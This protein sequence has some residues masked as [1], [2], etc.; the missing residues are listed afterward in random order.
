MNI[1]DI[2]IVLLLILGLIVGFKKGVIKSGVTL[3]GTIL[4][5][6]IS[7]YLKNPISAFMYT[8]FPFFNFGGAFAGITIINVLFYEGIAFLLVFLVLSIVLKLLIK[9]SGFTESIL[10]AT[11]ILSIPSKIL[12]AILGVI[13]SYVLIFIAL[14]TLNHFAFNVDVIKESNLTPKILHNTPILS[15]VMADKFKAIEEIA[16]LKTKYDNTKDKT[17]YNKEALEILLKYDIITAKNAEKINEKGK[18]KIEGATDI[19]N[20]YYNEQ[21]KIK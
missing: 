20:K 19:I 1:I 11:I 13:E 15:N 6:V 4:L 12:G 5:V 16:S 17:A 18:M 3:V 2:V 21:E 14:F 7:W 10:K 9:I 8:N